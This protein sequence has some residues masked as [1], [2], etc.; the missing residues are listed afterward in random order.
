MA[1]Q[2]DSL[3][4][5]LHQRF[6]D[7]GHRVIVLWRPWHERLHDWIADYGDEMTGDPSVANIIE[8]WNEVIT[9]RFKH[10]LPAKGVAV[11]VVHGSTPDYRRV[12]W[13]SVERF[14]LEITPRW[15]LSLPSQPPRVSPDWEFRTR[16]QPVAIGPSTPD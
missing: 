7:A 6:P 14:A 4:D 15:R 1:D 16:R 11:E 5:E 12:D 10:Q 2:D 3:I 13:A 9:P 8:W